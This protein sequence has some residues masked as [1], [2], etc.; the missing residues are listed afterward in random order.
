[1]SNPWGA[2]HQNK[3]LTVSLHLNEEEVGNINGWV[4][5]GFTEPGFADYPWRVVL[6]ERTRARFDAIA[7]QFVAAGLIAYPPGWGEQPSP[8]LPPNSTVRLHDMI[9]KG[10]YSRK[11]FLAEVGVVDAFP[12]VVSGPPYA[13]KGPLL[14]AAVSEFGGAPWIRVATISRTAGDLNPTTSINWS[15]GKEANISMLAGIDAPVGTMLY[16]NTMLDEDATPG[17]T[18]SGISIVWSELVE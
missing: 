2:I 14:Y 3:G 16:I 15:R 8:P 1:M 5:K 18:R 10:D 17:T 11:L 13:P 9:Q 12:F 7:A 6:E 4:N